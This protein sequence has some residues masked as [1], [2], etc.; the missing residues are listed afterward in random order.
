MRPPEYFG[1]SAFGA[2]LLTTDEL[3]LADTFQYSRQ[4][5]QNRCRI[6]T[7]AGLLWLSIPLQSHQRQRPI[8]EARIDNSVRWQVKHWR[9][10]EYNYRMTPY[11]EYYEPVIYPLYETRYDCLGDF[12]CASVQLLASILQANVKINRLSALGISGDS[13]EDVVE[14]AS[15]RQVLSPESSAD[16]D[17][18]R[19]ER[20]RSLRYQEEEYRQNFDGF[21]WGT[22]VVDRLFNRG[23][24]TVDDLLSGT[25]IAE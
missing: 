5:F 11:F 15:D 1:S 18:G 21:E 22:S 20:V 23:P 14:W 9:S 16:Y 2:L 7:P 17:R 3:V 10:F 13:L 4:S 6:R 25:T 8:R 12:T 19:L 24:A